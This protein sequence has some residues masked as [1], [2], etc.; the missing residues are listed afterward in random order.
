MVRHATAALSDEQMR[1][2][3]VVIPDPVDVTVRINKIVGSIWTSG[4]K[5]YHRPIDGAP[6]GACN[7]LRALC[8]NGIQSDTRDR[9]FVPPNNGSVHDTREIA[10]PARKRHVGPC[11]KSNAAELPVAALNSKLQTTP[12]SVRPAR[13]GLPPPHPTMSN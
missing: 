11:A 9:P 2:T 12:Q 8:I 1:A 7:S 10:V 6:G 4:D 3:P 13:R 5:Q